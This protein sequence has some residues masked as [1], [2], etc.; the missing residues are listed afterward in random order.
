MVGV[1]IRIWVPPGD[2][3]IGKVIRFEDD[4]TGEC[5][6]YV[7]VVDWSVDGDEVFI[8]VEDCDP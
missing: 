1:R 2:V 8:E 4:A 3:Q 5:P 6:C 7:R